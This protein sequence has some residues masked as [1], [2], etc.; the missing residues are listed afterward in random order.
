[1]A[2]DIFGIETQ[3]G[4]SWQLDGAVINIEGADDLV[5]T[6]ATIQYG[7]GVTKFSPLNQRKRY[8]LTGEANG[9]ITMGM[10]I[11][12]SKS[13]K[14]FLQRYADT[15]QVKKNVLAICPAG[16]RSCE[17]DLVPLQ[18]IC[19][20]VLIDNISVNVQQV[21]QSLTMVAAGLNMSF[22]SLYLK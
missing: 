22:V 17:D 16:V 2:K 3:I 14:T 20:G 7:R 21:G 13:I 18:F 9:V 11:G 4:G 1:M 12:P 5:V 19:N 6:A 8:L 15:C 10:I